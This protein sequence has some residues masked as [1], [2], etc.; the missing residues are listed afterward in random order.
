MPPSR[1]RCGRA[2]LARIRVARR[3]DRAGT[4]GASSPR[5]RREARVNRML[6][7]C[8]RGR[9]E[10]CCRPLIRSPE[11]RVNIPVP[12]FVSGDVH[13]TS[14]PRSWPFARPLCGLLAIGLSGC[15]PVG[16]TRTVIRYQ[17]ASEVEVA[18]AEES[19][20]YENPQHQPRCVLT[21]ECKVSRGVETGTPVLELHTTQLPLLVDGEIRV[22]GT[23]QTKAIE[24]ILSAEIG[25]DPS[26]P[27]APELAIPG[28]AGFR[29]IYTGG[30]KGAPLRQIG[31]EPQLQ[32]PCMTGLSTTFS[33]ASPWSNVK[34]IST[35]FYPDRDTAR[36]AVGFGLGGGFLAL[37]LEALLFGL[38]YRAPNSNQA[39]SERV[40]A[41][42]TTPLLA[43]P[44]LIAGFSML[45]TLI[46]P[47]TNTVWF[48]ARPSPTEEERH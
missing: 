2:R 29:A 4:A 26:H 10:S 39:F 12:G 23:D 46:A 37:G 9:T 33:L 48:K 13:S 6:L 31:S 8:A 34:E 7:G 43:I 25:P 28:C 44:S 5:L 47:D 35:G 15:A 24:D 22:Q 41:V 42:A 18:S 45:P 32:I 16:T 30:R 20:A 17:D 11:H 14:P 40:I 19:S 3:R 38:S 21:E 1:W 27:R 36:I